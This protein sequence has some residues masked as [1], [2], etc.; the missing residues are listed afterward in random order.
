MLKYLLLLTT[1]LAVSSKTVTS[2][3][4]TWLTSTYFRAGNEKVI[5]VLTGNTS[6]PQYTFT[7]SSA[8]TGTPS[9]AYGIKNYRGT[10]LPT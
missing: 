10:P 7:Y 3:T 6:T 4:P 5:A 2:V 8:L 1:V 9:L